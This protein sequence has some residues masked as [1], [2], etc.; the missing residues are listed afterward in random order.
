[1]GSS[2]RTFIKTTTAPAATIKPNAKLRLNKVNFN[3]DTCNL[4]LF[5]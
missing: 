1:M 2:L 5:K 3:S 4:N